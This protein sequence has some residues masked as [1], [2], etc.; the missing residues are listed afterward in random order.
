MSPQ[1]RTS[2]HPSGRGV[3]GHISLMRIPPALSAN[4]Y[5]AGTPEESENPAFPSDPESGAREERRPQIPDAGWQG[6]SLSRTKGLILAK[7]LLGLSPRHCLCLQLLLLPSLP[8]PVRRSMALLSWA[9]PS[10]SKPLFR[11]YHPTPAQP[12]LAGVL[13]DLD[14]S[15]NERLP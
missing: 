11:P 6:D 1:N 12:S 9:W 8:S 5:L 7:E 13:L 15:R 2:S 10:V 3:A 14:C 4:T